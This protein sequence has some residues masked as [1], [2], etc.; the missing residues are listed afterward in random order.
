[1]AEPTPRCGASVSRHRVPSLHF[2]L[3]VEDG[4]AEVRV[5]VVVAVGGH[6]IQELESG[7]VLRLVVDVRGRIWPLIFRS[8]ETIGFA[9]VFQRFGL[10]GDAVQFSRLLGRHAPLR[11]RRGRRNGCG[12]G[13]GILEFGFQLIDALLQRLELLQHL[14]VALCGGGEGSRQGDGQQ[15]DL[16]GT[17]VHRSLLGEEG[18]GEGFRCTRGWLRP[19]R[20]ARARSARA[21]M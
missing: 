5:P 14:G 3:E 15:R 19:F 12:L 13:L 7:Q 11:A 16:R 17:E 9:R 20:A 10:D 18:S 8:L 6:R 4:H 1:M 2:L 21:I